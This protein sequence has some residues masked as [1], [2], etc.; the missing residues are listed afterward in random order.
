MHESS[1]SHLVDP[2]RE[3]LHHSTD[4]LRSF[5]ERTGC[6]LAGL[7]CDFLPPEV[8]AACGVTALRVPLHLCG[9]CGRDHEH[10]APFPPGKVYDFFVAPAGCHS[11][12]RF[13]GAGKPVHRFSFP[14]GYGDKARESL[15]SEIRSLMES[16]GAPVMDRAALQEHAETYNALR[17]LMRGILSLRKTRPGMLSYRDL[18]VVI[19]SA[20]CLPPDVTLE[21]LALI[22]GRLNECGESS[23]AGPVVMVHGG[24]HDDW[25]VLDAL[26][27]AGCSVV[28]DDLC[29]GR[30]HF[31][32]SVNLSA[33]DVLA[34]VLDAFTFRP[35]CAVVRPPEERFELLYRLLKSHGV[36]LVV[37]LAGRCPA[38]DR[39]AEHLRVRLMRSG[40]DPLVLG[41]GADLASLHEY[42]RRR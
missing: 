22:L 36:E 4:M 35:L 34:E 11:L 24:F 25:A 20:S 15:Q 39:E 31:D 16:A 9:A 6:L 12:E 1:L 21:P 30:R 27:E 40:V 17:R 5:K 7:S 3:M 32:L 42:L 41:P 28:E 23:V 19:E 38:R 33:D 29:G 14:P 2:L 13:I 10:P 26:E 18:H 8:T 37:F